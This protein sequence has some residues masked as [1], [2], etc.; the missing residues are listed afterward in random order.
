[1][2][3]RISKK[4]QKNRKKLKKGVDKGEVVWYYNQALAREG[5]ERVLERAENLEND[6]EIRGK[7]TVNSGM[8]FNL[9]LV[10]NQ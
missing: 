10:K 2:N 7:T 6:T 1:M 5:P 9:G 8:S 4:F 3:V